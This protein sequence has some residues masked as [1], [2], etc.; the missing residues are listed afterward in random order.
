MPHT[1]AMRGHWPGYDAECSCGWAT[2]T[3]GAT[4]RYIEG[5]VW[6]HKRFPVVCTIEVDLIPD[7][8]SNR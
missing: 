3:G 2:R 1:A 7:E 6:L 4:R 5:E 8:L